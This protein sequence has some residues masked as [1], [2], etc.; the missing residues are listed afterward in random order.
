LGIETS[1]RLLDRQI[2]TSSGTWTKPADYAGNI[3]KGAASFVRIPRAIGG[4]AGG[5]GGG[6]GV[7]GSGGAAGGYFENVIIATEDVASSESVTIGAGGAGG[8]TGV[9]GSPGGDT[10]FGA[11]LIA[12]GGVAPAAAAA[13]SG[14]VVPDISPWVSLAGTGNIPGS[15]AGVSFENSGGNKLTSKPNPGGGPGA[16]GPGGI[17]SAGASGASRAGAD[18]RTAKGG[19]AGSGAVG[20]NGA[21]STKNDA[22]GGGGGGAE[23]YNGG[24]GG[25]YGAGGGGGGA[26]STSGGSGAGG[27]MVVEVWG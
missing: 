14:V 13:P 23:S 7:P 11:H 2:F 27:V 3:A 21:A 1:A 19:A 17:T 20:A 6:A 25:N 10:S 9:A 16:G 18:G 22:G 15:N 12:T 5:S 4:G 26:G 8:A 24:N